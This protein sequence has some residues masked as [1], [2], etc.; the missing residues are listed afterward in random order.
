MTR[1]CVPEQRLAVPPDATS[2]S[3]SEWQKKLVKEISENFEYEVLTDKQPIPKGDVQRTYADI[4]KAKK[5]LN[6]N[7]KTNL[8][9]G[10]K[11]FYEWFNSYYK[12]NLME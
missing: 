10:L 7:P 8:K 5:L 6:Y 9:N 3:D 12:L 1:R 11:K 4:S 2:N